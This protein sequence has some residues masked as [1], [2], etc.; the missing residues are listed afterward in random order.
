MLDEENIS[1]TYAYPNPFSPLRHNP[2]N[3]EG[4]V[5][6]HYRVKISGT[7]SVSVYDFAMALVKNVEE[8]ISRMGDSEYDAV[9]DGRNNFG[10]RVANGVYFYRVDLPGDNPVWGKVIVID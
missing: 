3:G 5:R 1:E 9:W 2:F 10:E 6:F 8:G 4:H 7:V